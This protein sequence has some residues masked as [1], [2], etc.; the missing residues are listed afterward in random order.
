[1]T[2]RESRME[3]FS[4]GISYGEKYTDWHEWRSSEIVCEVGLDNVDE[5]DREEIADAVKDFK[6]R[7]KEIASK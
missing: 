1:M 6:Q 2:T 5:A 4:F 3:K 7:L